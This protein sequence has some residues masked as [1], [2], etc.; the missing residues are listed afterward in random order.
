MA[1]FQAPPSLGNQFSDDSVLRGYLERTLPP[2]MRSEL[3]PV[4]LE[5]GERAGGIGACA[6]RI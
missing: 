3:E 4:L 6:W 2:D 5:L 1:F